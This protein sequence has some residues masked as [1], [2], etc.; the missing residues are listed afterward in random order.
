MYLMPQVGTKANL[1][2]PSRDERKAFADASIRENG[3]ICPT[4]SNPQYRGLVTEHGKHM[5][6]FPDNLSLSNGDID[7]NLIDNYGISLSSGK[8]ITLMARGTITCT[9]SI[10]QIAA[11]LAIKASQAKNASSA[12]ENIFAP[13][14]TGA[15]LKIQD[16]HD[17]VGVTGGIVK[18]WGYEGYRRYNDEP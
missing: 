10:I 7:I 2:I 17:M 6:L 13:G 9:A 15:S 1:H 18:G 3:E 12:N 14:S 5:D 4:T 8:N 16:Q 11:P